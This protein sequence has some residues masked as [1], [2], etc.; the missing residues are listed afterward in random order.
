MKYFK[1]CPI[2]ISHSIAPSEVG[3]SDQKVEN[4]CCCDVRRPM[5][6]PINQLN[7]SKHKLTAMIC[8]DSTPEID[9]YKTSYM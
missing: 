1:N 8:N 6:V 2:L 4:P 7:R 3:N 9:G 5:P